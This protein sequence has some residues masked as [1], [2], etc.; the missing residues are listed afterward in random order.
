[1]T[2]QQINLYRPIFRK[3]EKKFSAVAMGQAGLAMIAG[4]AA[5]YGLLW[6]QLQTTRADLRVVEK[7]HAE[8]T[9]QLQSVTQKFGG[10]QIPNSIDALE[11]ELAA[12]VS[13]VLT[14]EQKQVLLGVYDSYVGK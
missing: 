2:T 13:K 5:M 11:Q 7:R 12:E 14:A 3:Q 4:V 1:M 9:Q 6:W 8:V 10:D